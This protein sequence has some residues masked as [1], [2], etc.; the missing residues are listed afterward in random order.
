MFGA[1][2]PLIQTF[3]TGCG[4]LVTAAFLYAGAAASSLI[5]LGRKGPDA[6]VTRRHAARI[7][8]VALLGAALAPVCL[9]WGLK[10]VGGAQGSML[11]NFEA[12]FAVFFAWRIYREPIGKRV[13]LAAAL[14]VLGGVLLVMEGSALRRPSWGALA[15]VCATLAWAL[16]STLSRPLAELDVA[17]VI[18]WKAVAGALLCFGLAVALG[19]TFPTRSGVLGLLACGATGYGMSLR[20]YLLAQRHIG[21]ARTASIFAMAPFVGV[22]V[23]WMMGDRSMGLQGFLA[24]GFFGAGIYLHLTE[25]HKHAHLHE[26]LEHEHLHRHDD[27]HH[28]HLH[29]PPFV[30]EHSHTHVHRKREHEHEHAPDAHHVHSH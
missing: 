1:A 3:G 5:R 24:M 26:P 15:V 12:P 7:A 8:L 20:L 4:P 9:A 19:Q 30:G 28:D 6:S 10:H 14:I 17:V 2:T 23:A 29:E 11:L 27:E 22:L 21:A 25:R 16:D 13:A 18:R